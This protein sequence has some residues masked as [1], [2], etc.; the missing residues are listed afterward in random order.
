[1]TVRMAGIADIGV[2]GDGDARDPPG[3][4]RRSG[5]V[6]RRGRPAAAGSGRQVQSRGAVE[7]GA[8]AGPG[9]QAIGSTVPVAGPVTGHGAGRDR[10]PARPFPARSRRA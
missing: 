1:M 8:V 2:A 5:R 10:F 4:L 3:E 6:V 9:L 7:A